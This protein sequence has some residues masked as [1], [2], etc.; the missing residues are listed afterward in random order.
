MPAMDEVFKALADLT[1]RSL[2]D[3]L[4]KQDGQSLGALER[5]LPMPTKFRVA[6]LI[7]L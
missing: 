7:T 3:E 2:L 4:F 5:R 6:V 1:R